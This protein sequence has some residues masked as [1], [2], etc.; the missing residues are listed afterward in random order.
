MAITKYASHVGKK[1]R[2]DGVMSLDEYRLT[3][4]S[5]AKRGQELPQTKLL[6]L[7]VVTIK[8]AV[9]QR[10]KLRA[11]IRDNLSNAALAK[12]FNVHVRTVEKIIQN[13]TWSHIL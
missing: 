13:Y 1:I 4:T 3:A 11:Y 5:N 7:D 6:D 8:S 12:Q 10:E 2:R 9:R